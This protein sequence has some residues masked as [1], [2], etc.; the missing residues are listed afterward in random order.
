MLA[1]DTMIDAALCRAARGLLDWS[2]DQL[3]EAAQVSR[4]TILSFERGLSLPWRVNRLAIEAAFAAAGIRFVKSADG[5]GCI[6][7][8]RP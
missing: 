3:A 6:L 4:G 1:D 5:A 7:A 2:Q 8:G